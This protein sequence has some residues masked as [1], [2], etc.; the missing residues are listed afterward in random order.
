MAEARPG[1]H[2]LSQATRNSLL[3]GVIRLGGV[4]LSF[5]FF[6]A[7]ARASPAEAFGNFSVLFA[8]ATLL[9]YCA[10][11]GQHVAIIRFWP[12]VEAR[13]GRAAAD[14]ILG[15]SLGLALGGG[16]AGAALIAALGLYATIAG[17][18]DNTANLVIAG[19]LTFVM[20]AAEF[21]ANAMRA[22]GY[23]F[24][25][26][27][28]RD[29][30]WRLLVILVA[31]ALPGP[32]TAGDA[33]ALSAVLLA[34]VLAPQLAGLAK[35]AWQSRSAPVRPEDH[36]AL[37]RATPALWLGTSAL[38]V[39]EYATTVIVGLVLGPLAAGVYF[40]ADRLSKLLALGLISLEQAA[41]PELSRALHAGDRRLSGRLLSRISGAASAFTLSGF[42]A[43][44]L[45]GDR[46]LALFGQ[47]FVAAF[48]VLLILG[49]GQVVN[50]LCGA[51]AL[52]L[53]LAGRERSLLA[54]HTIWGSAGICL[55]YACASHMG[56][57]GAALASSVTLAGWNI[58]AT[59]VCR[60]D[61]GL[62]TVFAPAP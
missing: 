23:L 19:L 26:F 40:A 27:G 17:L 48:P 10:N 43:Y 15:R 1:E 53:N 22:R 55:A 28:P 60:R 42:I 38:P 5:A 4:G 9:G 21:A 35:V 51:N 39:M 3:V 61:L 33:L 2:V 7:I 8:L 47:E 45:F 30:V 49:A 13:S 57:V 18:I 24:R 41:G 58:S 11:I 12:S 46:A 14:A 16:A 62:A 32:L 20:A 56:L 25:A 44:C 29:I 31:L 34:L 54:I 6:L 59:I 52:L 37:L 50:A 36:R